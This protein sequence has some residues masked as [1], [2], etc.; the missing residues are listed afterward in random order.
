M[1]PKIKSLHYSPVKS[2]SF[3]NINQCKIVKNLGIMNDRIFAFS[4]EINQEQ[5]EIIEKYPA[6]R[7]LNNFLTLK[8]SPILNKYKFNFYHDQ[9]SLSYGNKL[10]ISIN[11]NN[12]DE[13]II[14]CKTLIE[15]EKSLLGPIYLLRNNKYP[16]F[17]TTHSKKISNTISLINLN[18]IK[19]LENKINKKI[20]FERFR[21]NFYIDGLKPWQER[22]WINKKILIN[23]A[24]FK[25]ID[26]ISRCSATNLQPN[27]DNVTINLPKFL[28]K[29]Y[30]HI[31]MGIYLIPLNDGQINIEDKIIINE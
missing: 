20:E 27:T 22:N 15:L 1:T 26:N 2:L 8:N 28:N 12:F 30:N 31:D 3:I 10:I 18:S 24:M 6:K 7:K 13:Y 16:F 25:V 21:G 23:N 14:L 19:D 9:L 17:D 5:S 11:S 29:H 4:R